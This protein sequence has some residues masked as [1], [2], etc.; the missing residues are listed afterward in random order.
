MWPKIDIW[1]CRPSIWPS[2]GHFGPFLAPQWVIYAPNSASTIY[3]LLGIDVLF[4]KVVLKLISEAGGH[5]D[6]QVMAIFGHFRPFPAIPGPTVGQICSRLSFK[7]LFFIGNRCSFNNICPEIDIWGWRP[8]RWPSYGHFWPFPAISGPKVGQV[9]SRP[10][11]N[12][13]F[14][15]G[16][17]CCFNN[18]CP[19]I[20]IWGCRCSRWPSFGRSRPPRG[21]RRSSP[22][23]KLIRI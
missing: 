19:K 5:P 14:Y 9:C 10:C 18:M 23:Q 16:N 22:K 4:T 17:Q 7:H 12:R 20:D 11:Y 1:G 13:P 21:P 3:F 8:S 2:Y 15:I 6:G